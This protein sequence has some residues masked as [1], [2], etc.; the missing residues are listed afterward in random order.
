MIALVFL[1]TYVGVARLSFQKISQALLA[2]TLPFLDI[3][4]YKFAVTV[5]WDLRLPRII[6]AIIAGFGLGI[7]G[8]TMQGILRNPLVSPFTLGLSSA[9]GFGAALAIVIGWGLVKGGTFFIIINAFVFAVLAMILVFFLSRLRSLNPVTLVLAGIA[10]MYLFSSMT[11]F[12]QYISDS[13]QLS[14]VVF[15]MMGS[16]ATSTW[17]KVAISLAILLFSITFL[18]KFSWEINAMVAGDEMAATLGTNVK[19]V[20]ILCMSFSTLIAAA[21]I[22]FTG[23]IGFIGLVA[24]HITRMIIGND[25]RYLLPLSGLTGAILLLASDILARTVF[26]PSELPLSVMTSFIGVPF[27][28]YILLTRRRNYF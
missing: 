11:S 8:A 14:G 12:L 26:L 9:A 20:R 15:W 16:L 4:S 24:P 6:M 21:I 19:A 13:D 3:E 1:A 10:I 7:S 23:V 5:V 22:S 2:K 28:V 17:L 25:Y 18:I 27:F